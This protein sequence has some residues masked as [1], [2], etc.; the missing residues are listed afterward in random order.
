[1]NPEGHPHLV[2]EGDI[3]VQGLTGRS[4]LEV[5][6]AGIGALHGTGLS[7]ASKQTLQGP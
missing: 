4:N 1:M 6:E 7:L 3:D 5:V 2:D